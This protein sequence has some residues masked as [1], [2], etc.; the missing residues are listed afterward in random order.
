MKIHQSQ[1]FKYKTLQKMAALGLTF[2]SI[3]KIFHN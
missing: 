3:I 2:N 1:E